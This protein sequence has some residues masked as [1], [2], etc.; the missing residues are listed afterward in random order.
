[1]VSPYDTGESPAGEVIGSVLAF[2]PEPIAEAILWILAAPLIL[3]GTV[4]G[5]LLL[6]L[7]A[8]WT[9]KASVFTAGAV[10]DSVRSLVIVLL[11]GAAISISSLISIRLLGNPLGLV[12][13]LAAAGTIVW[14]VQRRASAHTTDPA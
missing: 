6:A 12:V 13:S 2:L 1:M 3:V 14:I 10:L 8:V 5:V 7:I 11:V 9:W 4:L